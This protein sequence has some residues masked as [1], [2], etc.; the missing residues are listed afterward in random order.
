VPINPDYVEEIT[1]E[2][3]VFRNYEGRRFRYALTS[4]AHRPADETAVAIESRRQP[5]VAGGD[6]LSRSLQQSR[7]KSHFQSDWVLGRFFRRILSISPPAPS[8]S[9]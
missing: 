9:V 4:T 3:I 5:G 7:A 6:V 2:A 1:D 8:I